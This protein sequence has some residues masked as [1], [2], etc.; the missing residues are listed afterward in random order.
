[1]RKAIRLVVAM[2]FSLSLMSA[3]FAGKADEPSVRIQ[4]S[5]SDYFSAESV[6][7]ITIGEELHLQYSL[8]NK[9]AEAVSGLTVILTGYDAKGDV[10]GRE[11]WLVRTALAAGSK[12]TS[13]LALDLNMSS[14]KK[15]KVEFTPVSA[16]RYPVVILVPF[17]R[18]A[19]LTPKIFVGHVGFLA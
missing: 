19:Q 7:V 2:V 14:V 18:V 8:T 1:M 13:Q 16:A 15:M 9:S 10:A 11:T 3:G 4:I 5:P 6:K 17:A 12:T